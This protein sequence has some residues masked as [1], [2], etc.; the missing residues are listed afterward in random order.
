[1]CKKARMLIIIS[2]YISG[3]RISL[4]Y[5]HIICSWHIISSWHIIISMHLIIS[6]RHYAYHYIYTSLYLCTSLY[7]HII[8]CTP[9]YL[10]VIMH[11]IISTHHYIYTVYMRQTRQSCLLFKI[12]HVF[13]AKERI[14][15]N[16]LQKNSTCMCVCMYSTYNDVYTYIH[17]QIHVQH[18]YSRRVKTAC[19]WRQFKSLSD[20][21]SLFLWKSHEIIVHICKFVQKSSYK[22]VHIY[23]HAKIR[24]LSA[25]QPWHYHTLLHIGTCI[26]SSN[27]ADALKLLAVEDSLRLFL[28]K[29]LN[30][31]VRMCK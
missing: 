18:T 8:I 1:M 28:R 30:M 22:S 9:V 16:M 17:T 26:R 23:T 29:S 2:Q 12:M 27:M 13:P 14:S 24:S 25:K 10:H 7:L 31:I 19:C 11:I 15:L 21:W 6:T 4:L 20:S 5:L 3:R